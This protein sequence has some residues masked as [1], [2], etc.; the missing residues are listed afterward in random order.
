MRAQP[1]AEFAAPALANLA[2]DTWPRLAA[3]GRLDRLASGLRSLG[4]PD[5]VIRAIMDERAQRKGVCTAERGHVL[6]IDTLS[7][8]ADGPYC[9]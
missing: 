5:F 1:D 3:G 9:Q 4:W 2:A 8:V 7:C 6:T